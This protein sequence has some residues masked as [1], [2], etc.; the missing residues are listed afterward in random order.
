LH[1]GGCGVGRQGMPSRT[2]VLRPRSGAKRLSGALQAGLVG[3][4]LRTPCRCDRGAQSDGG[5]YCRQS[6]TVAA[7]WVPGA[8][9]VWYVRPGD[10]EDEHVPVP[11]IPD[12]GNPRE[13]A[14]RAGGPCRGDRAAVQV[15]GQLWRLLKGVRLGLLP[16]RKP[17]S[18]PARCC[19]RVSRILTSAVS[20]G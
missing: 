13:A 8:A 14:R 9:C 1:R 10:S 2:G 18:R 5:G 16:A 11:W 7:S 3:P 4:R 17:A 15:P 20:W 19:I 12:P 6:G